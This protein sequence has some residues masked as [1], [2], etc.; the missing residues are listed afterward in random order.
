MEN[1]ATRDVEEQRPS[2]EVARKS[3]CYF[4]SEF[5]AIAV[6]LLALSFGVLAYTAPWNH[7]SSTTEPSSKSAPMA[8]DPDFSA[9]TS[10]VAALNGTS[11]QPSTLAINETSAPSVGQDETIA[12]VASP[13]AITKGSTGS[14]VAPAAAAPASQTNAPT[15]ATAFPTAAP[16]DVPELQECYTNLTTLALILRAKDPFIREVY[17]LCPNTVFEMGYND[18]SGLCCVNG[19][20]P[21]YPRRFTTVQCGD[22]GSSTNNC[23]LRGGSS[24]VLF[25]PY[26]STELKIDVFLRGLTFVEAIVS[27]LFVLGTGEITFDDCIIKVRIVVFR[28][29]RLLAPEVFL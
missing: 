5:I 23:T 17:K 21:I 9:P 18:A 3:R 24:Q 2:N 20:S 11:A 14:A 22:D 26:V 13:A 6:A 27:S 7:S 12:P 8:S 28:C 16:F 19:F 25:G 29:S 15:P 10:P 4:S 1:S